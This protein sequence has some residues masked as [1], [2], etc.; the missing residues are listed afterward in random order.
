MAS[1]RV[2]ASLLNQGFGCAGFAQGLDSLGHGCGDLAFPKVQACLLGQ[3]LASLDQGAG[4]KPQRFEAAVLWCGLHHR[5]SMQ[6]RLSAPLLSFSL[7]GPGEVVGLLQTST[8][9]VSHA[10]QGI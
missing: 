5:P 4:H 9:G 3:G 6:D 10:S 2:L 7:A 1:P 8:L